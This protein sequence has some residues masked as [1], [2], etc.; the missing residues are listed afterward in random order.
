[1]ETQ[2]TSN[3][4]PST[5]QTIT[6]RFKHLR[7]CAFQRES[8]RSELRPQSNALFYTSVYNSLRNSHP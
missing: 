7:D 3:E 8:S 4:R 6:F 5:N 2:D 1:M